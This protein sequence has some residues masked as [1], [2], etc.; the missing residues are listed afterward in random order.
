MRKFAHRAAAIIAV[1]PLMFFAGAGTAQAAHV[2]TT[3]VG[4]PTRILITTTVTG[5][6]APGCRADV[7]GGASQT[8]Q[9]TGTGPVSLTFRGLAAG[10]HTVNWNCG[11]GP[12]SIPNVVVK[13]ADPVGDALNMALKAAG[14]SQLVTDPTCC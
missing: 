1:A 6:F 8:Y 9:A 4:G 5:A 3:A 11:E 2:T 12:R 7:D 10:T 13:A 14:S